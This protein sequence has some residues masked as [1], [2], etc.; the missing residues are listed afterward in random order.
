MPA[1]NR[2]Y[3]LLTA[4]L[5][6]SL[7]IVL[8]PLNILTAIPSVQ[9]VQAQGL[10]RPAAATQPD[11]LQDALSLAWAQSTFQ[12][13][14]NLVVTYSAR[15]DLGPALKP[16]VIA[17]ESVTDT[18]DALLATDFNADPNVIHDA[19]LV[20]Q[21]THPQV[22][23]LDASHPADRDG[24]VFAFN[25]GDL[26]PLGTATVV[27]TLTTPSSVA[28]FTPLDSGASV[29]GNWQGRTMRT[30]AT[31]LQLAPDGFVQ[32][33]V[34]TPDANCENPDVIRQAA[35][36]EHDPDAIFEYVRSLGYESY[37]GS[38]RG[39]RGT[40]WSEAGN[41]FDQA[42][43]LIALMRASGYP[44]AYRIGA[45]DQ[46]N[47]RTLI[48]SM[49][50]EVTAPSG[51]IPVG[52]EVADPANDP[53]LLAE[54]QEHA[55]AEAYLP[56]LGWTILD[57]AFP[58]SLKGDQFGTPN[59][60]KIAELPDT[61]RHKLTVA[62]EVEKYSAFPVGGINLYSLKPLTATFNVVDLVGEP[63]IFA[64]L[65]NST[66]QTGMVFATTQ[67][68]Y[69]PYFVAGASEALI[70]GEAFS[71]LISNFPL[72]QDF[73]TAEWL[74]FTIYDPVG[75]S[76][77]YRRE[78]FDDIGY[79]ARV[80]GGAVGALERDATARVSLM[81]SWTTLVAPSRV[82]LQA[83]N[84]AYQEIVDSSLEGIDVRDATAGLEDTPNPT[85]E[86]ID[87]ARDAV[88]VYGEMARLNQRL[89]LY[90]FAAASHQGH[91]YVADA[92][93]VKT[94]P[95]TPRLFTVGWERNDQEKTD[96]ITFDLLR[97]RVR[98][99]AYPGQTEIGLE[100]FN[101]WRALLDMAIEHEVLAEVAPEPLSSV[102]V[103]FEKALADGVPLVR[104]TLG[105]LDKLEGL[106]L[107]DQ[108]KARITTALSDDP[109]QYVIVPDQMVTIEG[110][111]EPTVGWLEIHNDTLEVIDTMENGQHMAAFSYSALAEF[112][113]KAGSFIG[114][115][116]I[117]FFAHTMGFW[118]GF[119]EQMP[120]ENQDIGQVI[121]ASKQ[122][123]ADWGASADQYCNE[124]AD[125]KWCKRGIAVGNAAGAAILAKAD[126]P[127]QDTLF[128]LPLDPP[129]TNSHV[130]TVLNQAASLS[131]NAVTAA[132][133]TD[134]SAFYGTST[135]TWTA[136]GLNSFP[137][138]SLS[139]PSAELYDGSLLLDSGPLTAAPASDALATAQSD[140]TA[141]A[142]DGLMAG[143]L[144][145]HANALFDLG[146][147]SEY[148]S[149][150]INLSSTSDYTLNLSGA[151]VI[152]NGNFFTGD[153]QVV[154]NQATTLT[155]SGAAAVPNF[156]TSA[157]FTPDGGGITVADATGT[158][159]VGGS[160]VDA[161][162]GFALGNVNGLATLAP[163]GP[164][165][166]FSFNGTADFFTLALSDGTSTISSGEMTEFD[167]SLLANFAGTYTLTASAPD[168]WDLSL[169]ENGHI[170]AQS[171]AG[172]SADTYSIL[173]T[174]QS[175]DYADLF[176]SYVHHVTV[177]GVN[178]VAVTVAPDPIYTVPWG[179]V[180]DVINF[181]NTVGRVQIPDAAFALTVHNTSS[182]AQTYNLDVS[183]LPAGWS[184]LGG[185]AGSTH[186]E[187]LLEAGE[188]VQLG[189][190]ISPAVSSLPSPGSTYPFSVIVTAADNAGVNDADSATFTM[191]SLPYPILVVA[192]DSIYTGENSS[193]A[194]DVTLT[195]AGNAA[196][197][198]DLV[199]RVPAPGWSV[200]N[201]Q[202]PIS[203]NPGE[204]DTQSVTVNV[205]TG[206]AGVDYPVSIGSPA[207]TVPYTPTVA[208]NVYIAEPYSLPIFQAAQG[209]VL[210]SDSLAAALESLALAVS[211]LESSCTEGSCSI[212]Y[213][214]RTVEAIRT[215][216]LYADSASENT[217]ATTAGSESDC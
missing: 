199:S 171:P 143:T 182:T 193:I 217:A 131:G 116:S 104:I 64:H 16:E 180:T 102:G 146:A 1:E 169:D 63:L 53:D 14:N 126:P 144:S 55:W 157:T 90:K 58:T 194:F 188:R 66:D 109:N 112:S 61:I 32:W 159:S 84:N 79:Q 160:T 192:P 119:F 128:V 161:S 205:T 83:I 166:S 34:C 197:S 135:Q 187:L 82:P 6:L 111:V 206:D 133:T 129:V 121:S 40:I 23:L 164:Q 96:S 81:S 184:I 60:D 212:A 191:P 45:L 22:D 142:V 124:K 153:L 127:L 149:Q 71:E 152:V 50:P 117:G 38:L 28:A 87:L 210:D 54:A 163:A 35:V 214:D 36:L 51:H 183:G 132:V 43:L 65:V 114:G 68:T 162:H 110:A 91:D 85:Q 122:V 123:A 106:P 70:E 189:L 31:P 73:V 49:F 30:T 216:T 33:L 173:V 48:A 154:T 179:P 92:L 201:L 19:H 25:L 86:Q 203:L 185:E 178:G 80:G 56:G 145:M 98:A 107:S 141:I 99:M 8:L 97:N 78:L 139:I 200:T 41:G 147:G 105:N 148:Q 11:A 175:I 18:V 137:F 24:D 57:P 167:A 208:I 26:A 170:T 113:V 62:L 4:I 138:D 196:G 120:L 44:A 12:A 172:A 2:N 165:D 9:T 76:T 15:N 103:V 42:S 3:H 151:T 207:P 20:I 46:T 108:A 13:G 27:L 136:L 47:A 72:G 39:A 158:L 10:T 156:S 37:S 67:H 7:A 174:A 211:D 140:G 95:D 125:E 202:D 94:Y 198:F 215:L 186:M 190:Y 75:S 176:V 115:F 21:L 29:Y 134:L 77:T 177:T 195:N 204:S 59:G 213:R 168:G 93:L 118:I 155:A 74:D 52:S 100:G 69:T 150:S 101:F 130:S 5:R 209:C 17:G 181:N 88:A 89:H